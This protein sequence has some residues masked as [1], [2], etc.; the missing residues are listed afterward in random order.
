[1][2]RAKQR[3]RERA[4]QRERERERRGVRGERKVALIQDMSLHVVVCLPNLFKNEL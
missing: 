4:K 2:E 3:E 1:M